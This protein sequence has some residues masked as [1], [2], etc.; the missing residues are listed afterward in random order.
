MVG[1]FTVFV[2][3]AE[4]VDGVPAAVLEI[5]EIVGG[6]VELADDAS[7]GVDAASSCSVAPMDDDFDFYH[8][9]K[10]GMEYLNGERDQAL[11]PHPFYY[12]L[13]TRPLLG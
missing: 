10:Q 13:A 11:H 6:V 7:D 2:V 9:T 8:I 12:G 4:R 3:E 5:F 1:C